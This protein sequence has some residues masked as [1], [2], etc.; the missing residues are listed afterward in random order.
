MAYTVR[1]VEY[2]AMSVPDKAGSGHGSSP[3]SPR[4]GSTCSR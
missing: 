3:R 4:T 2:F 1:T